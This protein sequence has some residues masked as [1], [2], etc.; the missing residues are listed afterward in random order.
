MIPRAAA[1]ATGSV[2]AVLL[3][4]C[5][6]SGGGT[7]A[8][9]APA[10]TPPAA[11]GAAGLVAAVTATSLQVQNP[12]SGQVAVD[13]TGATRITQQRPA[14]LHAVTKGDCVTAT[15][16][17]NS[18]GT[19]LA[20]RTITVRPAVGGSCAAGRFGGGPGARP[21]GVPRPRPS[22]GPGAARPSGG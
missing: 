17:P 13:F 3:A 1:L 16:S 2:L 22:G 8:P 9:P 15:G 4:A 20:A 7:V 11:P 12:A 6:N 19:G 21:S 18:A 14:T 5:G 10:A